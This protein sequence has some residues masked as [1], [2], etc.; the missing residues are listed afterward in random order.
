M[1][2]C[3]GPLQNLVRAPTQKA[4]NLEGLATWGFF[5]RLDTLHVIRKKRGPSHG[6]V[7]EW[8]KKFPMYLLQTIRK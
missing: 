1:S 8:M 5:Y 7:S 2:V 4:K 6:N 3:P